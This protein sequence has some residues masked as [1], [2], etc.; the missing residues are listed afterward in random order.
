MDKLT[1][2]CRCCTTCDKL[3]YMDTGSKH[4]LRTPTTDE[5]TTNSPPTDKN[6]PHPNILTCSALALR[7]GKFVVELLSACPLVVS[8]ASVHTG[9]RSQCPCSEVCHMLYNIYNLLWAHLLVVSVGGVV[10][11]VCI[12]GCL[13]RGVWADVLQANLT[14][15]GHV[16]ACPLVVSIAGVRV[17]EFG[18]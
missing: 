10:Q 18:P 12:A 15:N 7:Y 9:V 5:L 14:G 4:R 3:H 1:T 2:S 8:V 13:C 11:H 16:V 6:L 17:V